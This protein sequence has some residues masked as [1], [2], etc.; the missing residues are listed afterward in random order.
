MSVETLKT[1]NKY[2]DLIKQRLMIIPDMILSNT[3]TS[4]TKVRN[5]KP[6]IPAGETHEVMLNA[7]KVQITSRASLRTIAI[8]GIHYDSLE[9]AACSM[10][11]PYDEYFDV[12]DEIRV[13]MLEYTFIP[14]LDTKRDAVR[15]TIS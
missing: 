3:I 7:K 2:I 1:Y 11:D 10:Y 9:Q 4:L 5:E 13:N 6:F 15:Y 14:I 12:S 8:D